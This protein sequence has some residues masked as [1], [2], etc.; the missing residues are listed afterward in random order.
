[1]YNDYSLLF[2]CILLISTLFVASLIVSKIV[3]KI[4][5]VSVDEFEK[6]KKEDL[7]LSVNGNV[8]K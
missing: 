6:F 1:M 8:K 2:A 7:K 4:K 5:S 3:E